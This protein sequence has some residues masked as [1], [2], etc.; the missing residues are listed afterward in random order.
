MHKGI[1]K[2]PDVHHSNWT[3]HFCQ[4]RERQKDGVGAKFEYINGTDVLKGTNWIVEGKRRFLCAL[5]RYELYILW[6]V[7]DL[8]SYFCI[9][10]I[11]SKYG[12]TFSFDFVTGRVIVFHLIARENSLYLLKESSLA[13][14]PLR[15]NN[16]EFCEFPRGR[17][18]ISFQFY[19]DVQREL[20]NI[21]LLLYY[22]NIHTFTTAWPSKL[23]YVSLLSALATL[24]NSV[25]A[26][27]TR[28]SDGR[29]SYSRS[30]S[31]KTTRTP[32]NDFA[33]LSFNYFALNPRTDKSY[34]CIK[35]PL[36]LTNQ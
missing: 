19:V 11:N 16:K 18:F 10:C 13:A 4:L 35:S 29:W 1:T 5:C 34:L 36:Q 27:F 21:V 26:N 33:Q 7:I 23:I 8:I 9:S 32:A 28:L 15:I 20:W 30:Q 31:V 25:S 14:S 17:D 12:Y 3:H 2:I 22:K 6:D 24:D